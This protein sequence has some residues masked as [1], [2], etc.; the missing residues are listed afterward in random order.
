MGRNRNSL[1]SRSM[2]P[3]LRYS[4]NMVTGQVSEPVLAMTTSLPCLY[5]SVLLLRIL[6]VTQLEL[7]CRSHGLM[8]ASSSYLRNPAKASKHTVASLILAK[9]L[10]FHGKWGFLLDGFSTCSLQTFQRHPY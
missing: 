3:L 9:L 4:S 1:L 6:T 7:S 5:W 10:F 2:A 8:F